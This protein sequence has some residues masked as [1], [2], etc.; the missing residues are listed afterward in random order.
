MGVELWGAA[1]A[2]RGGTAEELAWVD[3]GIEGAAGLATGRETPVL[4][5]GGIVD[6]GLG[7]G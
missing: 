7:E 6:G 5:E 2:A 4:L 1:G 3:L